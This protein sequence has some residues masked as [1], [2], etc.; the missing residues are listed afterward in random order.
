MKFYK[1]EMQGLFMGEIIIKIP[2]DVHE[3]IKLD[4][5]YKEVKEKLKE[6]EENK[7]LLEEFLSINL[8]EKVKKKTLDDTKGDFYEAIIETND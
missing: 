7:K 2:E 6:M 1:I 8:D 3:E 4:I 5:S